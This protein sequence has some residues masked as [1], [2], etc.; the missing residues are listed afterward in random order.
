MAIALVGTIGVASQGAASAA[1]TPAWGTS[2]SRTAGNL[3]ICFV[4]VTAVATLPTQ[5]SGWST[6][7]TQA[8]TSCSAAIFYKVATGTDTAPT[9]AAITSGLIAAQLAEFSGTAT[10]T[11]LDQSGG[12]A[13]ATSP[14]TATFG[15]ADAA[16]TDLWLAASGDF[17]SASTRTPTDTITGNHTTVVQAG[18]N[19][20]VASANHYSFGYDLGTNSNSGADT[21]IVTTSVATSLTGLVIAAATLKS[22][23]APQVALPTAASL[24]TSMGTPTVAVTNNVTV[25]PGAAGGAGPALIQQKAN[26]GTGSTL[27]VTLDAPC[28][29]GNTLILCVSASN[30]L[31]SSISGGGTWTVARGYTSNVYNYIQ[32][33][34]VDTP[35]T[36]V[37]I[38]FSGVEASGARA[39]L[40]EWSGLSA[41]PLDTVN[42]STGSSTAPTTASVTPTV[43]SNLVTAFESAANVATAGPA[44][45]W[46]GLTSTSQGWKDSYAYLIQSSATAASTSWTTATGAWDSVIVAFKGGA[47]A[48]LTLAGAVPA[49]TIAAPANIT[50]QPAA[51]TL[52][53]SGA[54]P[55]VTAIGTAVRVPDAASLTLTGSAPTVTVHNPN[56]YQLEDGSGDYQLE[57]GSGIYLGE[58]YGASVIAQPTAASMT[59]A[60]A[61]PAVTTPV[62]SLPGS[63][64]L[65]LAGTTP[66]V[67]TPRLAVPASASFTLTGATPAIALPVVSLPGSAGLTM[68][69]E[70]PLVVAIGTA[71]AQPAGASLTLSGSAPTVTAVGTALRVPGA[72]SLILTGATPD[73]S[74]TT[75]SSIVAQP[76]A[77]SLTLA[78]AVP[79]VA[80]IG[81]TH[82]QP[83]AASL[84]LAGATPAVVA[85]GTA[86]RVPAAASLALTGAVPVVTALAGVNPNPA[87]AALTLTGATPTVAAIGTALRVPTAASLTLTGATPAVAAVGTALRVPTAAALTLAGAIPSVVALAP[88]AAVPAPASLPLT[89]AVPAVRT[90]V[91]VQPTAAE[92]YLA[93]GTPV[94]VASDHIVVVPGPLGLTL[95]GAV[96][97]VIIPAL[98]PG[99]TAHMRI[100]SEPVGMSLA[101]VPVPQMR[102]ASASDRPTIRRAT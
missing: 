100:A 102:I 31:L 59:M 26:V 57:D 36:A 67:L 18:N 24:T 20:T 33:A 12:A 41:T 42:N 43:A 80:A 29:V 46:L 27:V 13:A 58:W 17:R 23:A 99:L 48:S 54:T 77:A 101:S 51:A 60:G 56:G 7:K 96:P 63:V 97:A 95:T 8:G 70:A 47:A 40:S 98:L 4:A 73:V 71:S 86:V 10:S 1:V 69:G 16:I 61:T 65:T 5:P 14:V 38:T 91:T 90:P 45:S 68:A 81:T 75:G 6:A 53:L 37:T 84:A 92:L 2:E 55:T 72:A 93:F 3:L 64:G 76:S 50:A 87:G 94:V 25:V 39:N 32:Y 66:A 11:P 62:V 74:V 21:A 44:G 28:A 89:G 52:A 79:A 78:G 34:V 19:N 82:P 22:N 49:V 15:G 30:Y 35:V 9:I 88:V 85:I 83:S